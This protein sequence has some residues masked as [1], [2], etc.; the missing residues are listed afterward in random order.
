[1]IGPFYYGNR[2]LDASLDIKKLI[3]EKRISMSTDRISKKEWCFI[4]V[5]MEYHEG[6]P[7]D[8][9]TFFQFDPES[10]KYYNN[11]L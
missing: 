5:D 2:Y 9:Y 10:K 8:F 4:E 3:I 7:E 1:M 6:S 11:P